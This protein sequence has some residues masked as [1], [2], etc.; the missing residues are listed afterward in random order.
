MLSTLAN[1]SFFFAAGC[2]GLFFFGDIFMPNVRWFREGCA[3]VMMPA[4]MACGALFLLKIVMPAK[5]R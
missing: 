3:D 5:I 4:V 1:I 2:I